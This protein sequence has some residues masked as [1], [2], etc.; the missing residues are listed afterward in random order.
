MKTFDERNRTMKPG[1]GDCF[2][3]AVRPYAA[4]GGRCS[5][6]W[7]G[8]AVE[9]PS[10]WALA[11]SEPGFRPSPDLW[12]RSGTHLWRSLRVAMVWRHSGLAGNSLM[13]YSP[14][15]AGLSSKGE[16]APAPSRRSGTSGIAT[17][18]PAGA[19]VRPPCPALAAPGAVGGTM[20]DSPVWAGWPVV[21]NAGSVG[22]LAAGNAAENGGET[23]RR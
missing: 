23:P 17:T 8:P 1:Y 18:A 13:T 6:T 11:R 5:G 2:C 14:V 22:N 3:D 4:M 20:P 15:V 21:R 9:W 12:L 7:S 10:V 19:P 16:T